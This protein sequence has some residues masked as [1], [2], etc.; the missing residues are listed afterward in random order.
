MKV[1][2]LEPKRVTAKRQ[3]Q[4]P[5]SPYRNGYGKRIPSSW[6]LQLDGKQWHRVYVICYSNSGSPYVLSKGV[7]LFLGD[8]IPGAQQ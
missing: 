8:Y 7:T 2:Y 3:T 1:T 5:Q 6:L 4:P